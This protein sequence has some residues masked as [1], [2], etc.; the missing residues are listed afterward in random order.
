MR[1]ML[2]TRTVDLMNADAS[3]G[4][5]PVGKY[6]LQVKCRFSRLLHSW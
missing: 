1:R 2:P 4:K 5:A 6:D 3:L